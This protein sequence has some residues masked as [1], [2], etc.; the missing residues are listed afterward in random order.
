MSYVMLWYRNGVDIEAVNGFTVTPLP[1]MGSDSWGVR[2]QLYL[3][4][5]ATDSYKFGVFAD[6]GF[7]FGGNGLTLSRYVT[8]SAAIS[9]TT[10]ALTL[11]PGVVYNF[12][13]AY[14]NYTSATTSVL[15]LLWRRGNGALE[16]VPSA[17][18]HARGRRDY[19]SFGGAV[20]AVKEG[21]IST[22]PRTLSYPHGDHLGSTSLTTNA[23]GQKVSEQRYKPYG[24]VR[25]SSG[26]GLPTDF[27]FTG[28]RASSY[29]TIFMSA[30]EY[31]LSP[32]LDVA[33]TRKVW[34]PTLLIHDGRPLDAAS[35]PTKSMREFGHTHGLRSPHL[36]WHRRDR[37][38][39]LSR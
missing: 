6:D 26:A 12:G 23:S 13:L 33:P 37:R 34:P 14:L 2:F 22:A 9:E 17:S 27:T 8:Q 19:Y 10:S 3:T 30:R 15:Q 20:V 1:G 18:I 11:T 7:S 28:Q 29:G 32:A 39:G 21:V 36:Q 35:R 16:L 5:A 38:R 24:E 31:L 25:W 4:V